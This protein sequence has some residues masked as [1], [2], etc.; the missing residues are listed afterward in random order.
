[1]H[2]CIQGA[3]LSSLSPSRTEQLSETIMVELLHLCL[4]ASDLFDEM[5]RPSKE[6]KLLNR[7]LRENES[8]VLHGEALK[9]S[10]PLLCCFWVFFIIPESPR[11]L[12]KRD[13]GKEFEAALRTL[14]GKDADICQE[15]DDFWR[16]AN[17]SV[18]H[19][20]LVLLAFQ[21]NFLP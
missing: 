9:A 18:S 5:L 12:V 11:W 4:Y 7:S 10:Y 21:H 19:F 1:M 17:R 14:C 3:N 6:I 13:R 20:S 15:A 2:S 8:L 16:S